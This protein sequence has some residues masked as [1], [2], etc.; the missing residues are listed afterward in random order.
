MRKQAVALLVHREASQVNAL[1]RMLQ[2]TFDIFVHIDRKSDLQVEDIDTVN[3]WKKYNVP[4]GGY[5]M[6]EATAFLYRQI[7]ETGK[8]YTHVILLSGDALPVKSNQFISDFLSKHRNVSFIENKLADGAGLE[9]R[10]LFWFNEDLKKKAKGIRKYMNS[11]RAIRWV[12]RRLKIWRDTQGFERTGSQWT[13]LSLHHVRHL[14]ENCKLS[15][16]RFMAVPDESFVQNHFS[17]FNLPHE[18]NLIYAHWPGQKSSSPDY[19]DENTFLSLISNSPYL[20]AR[21]FEPQMED[22]RKSRAI[23]VLQL[24]QRQREVPHVRLQF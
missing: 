22:V 23:R 19:I 20:F 13:I 1:I 17:N 9:R 14:I 15:Q 7:L 16:Y 24:V 6:I 18:M 12:Q 10:R 4:W 3:V 21:K 8:P 5:D 11:Y 2:P